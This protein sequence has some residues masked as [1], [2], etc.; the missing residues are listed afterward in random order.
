MKHCLTAL[1]LALSS[2]LLASPAD[3][4]NNWLDSTFTAHEISWEKAHN[5]FRLYAENHYKEAENV[6]EFIVQFKPKKRKKH[7]SFYALENPENYPNF[8]QVSLQAK[9][10][11][12]ALEKFTLHLIL[13]YDLESYQNNYTRF[14]LHIN[15]FNHLP[16]NNLD[17]IK[18]R[19]KLF[20]IKG[21][22]SLNPEIFEKI[23]LTL[24]SKK[25]FLENTFISTDDLIASIDN[26]QNEDSLQTETIPDLQEREPSFIG[27]AANMDEFVQL[28]I[29]Y[30]FLAREMGERG[31]VYVKFVVNSKGQ[32]RNIGIRK[33]ISDSIDQEAMRIFKMMPLWIPGITEGKLV[34]V[35]FTLALNFRLA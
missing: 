4:L 1:I 24:L 31:N 13:K 27:G 6:S 34:S 11:L 30:P 15:Y 9:P 16:L 32:I 25:I 20:R 35:H 22:F 12:L 2:T 10:I 26:W 19:H 5:E 21:F 14:L 23:G 29:H 3:D 17:P 7:P 28:N 8:E 33:G 18:M